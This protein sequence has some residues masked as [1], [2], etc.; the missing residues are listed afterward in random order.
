LP[1]GTLLGWCERLPPWYQSNEVPNVAEMKIRRDYY[2][3][4][5]PLRTRQREYGVYAEEVLA[6]YAPFAMFVIT[7]IPNA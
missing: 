1:P 2:R 6:I 5:W 3:V 4:D 7:N